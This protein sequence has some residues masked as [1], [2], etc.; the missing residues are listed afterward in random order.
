MKLSDLRKSMKKSAAR[1]TADEKKL[2]DFLQTE[3]TLPKH[4]SQKCSSKSTEVT[5][6][7]LA[8]TRDD[9]D[10]EIQSAVSKQLA[11]EL[12]VKTL[13]YDD[14]R[15]KHCKLQERHEAST[16]RVRNRNKK[17]KTRDRALAEK[18]EMIQEKTRKIKET[19]LALEGSDRK[20]EQ[21]TDKVKRLTADKKRLEQRLH[22]WQQKAELLSR[23]DFEEL[24]EYHEEIEK[25]KANVA[26]LE[27]DNLDLREQVEVFLKS[28]E[29]VSF[30]GG[31]Y[32]DDIRACYYELLSL[33]VG[34]RNVE[35]IIRSVLHNI[36]HKTVGRLP[37]Y[38]LASKMLAE[39]LVISHAQ[40][41]E[42][43][44]ET[45]F[46]TLH[47]DGTT[48]YGEHYGAVEI[49]TKESTYSIGMR[50][51]FSGSA[52]NTLDILQE[53]LTDIDDVGT[54][55]G[56][57]PALGKVLANVKNTM[58]DRHVVQKSF[59]ELLEN[60]RADIL[61]AVVENWDA[62]SKI[63]Q[64]QTTRLNNFF[65]G[66][67]FIT[68]L[69]DTAEAVLKEWE[70]TVTTSTL[71]KSLQN[72]GFF[73]SESGTQRL[74]RTACKAL[75]KRG[76]EQAG[77]PVQFSTFLRGKG[78]TKVP[79]ASF[80]GNRFNIIFYDA[81]GIYYLHSEILEFLE[82]HGTSNRL[83]CSVQAHL[84]VP[85]FVAGCK[86]L[87]LIDKLVTGPLWRTLEES[88][89]SI[90]DMSAHYSEMLEM[91]ERWS[92]DA[93][94]L[95]AGNESLPDGKEIADDPVRHKLLEPS[96]KYD[97]LAQEL[98]EVMF[99][100]FCTT[101]RRMLTDHLPGG[102]F[103]GKEDDSELVSE[104]ASVPKTNVISERDFAMLD[105]MI[106]DKPN[107]TTVALEAMILYANNQ[108]QM[109][110]DQHTLGDR[111]K[112]FAVA[113]KM[114]T[115]VKQKFHLR[116]TKIREQ[117]HERQQ[118]ELQTAERKRLKMLKDKEKWVDA[119]QKYGLWKSEQQIRQEMQ[120]LTAS[121]CKN[122]VITQIRFRQKVLCQ[123][124][125]D[126][127]VFVVTRNRKV[128]PQET[129]IENLKKLLPESSP[130]YPSLDTGSTVTDPIDIQTITENPHKLEGKR[131]EHLFYDPETDITM[132][133]KGT[134]LTLV[135]GTQSEFKVV[136]DDELD[137]Q[138][139]FPLLED[140]K[141]GDLRIL[142]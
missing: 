84:H 34:L 63:E 94:S 21:V 77:C 40:L 96:E 100:A 113:R 8:Y 50:S 19:K 95:L 52:Q 22:Y 126:S 128:L 35:P 6:G 4:R 38:A 70:A 107:A 97:I 76:S 51:M 15:K 114:A 132:W 2:H 62:M 142:K 27:E 98:L 3:F 108:T 5:S 115:T 64:E 49:S 110:L 135:P 129:L 36:A 124:Y 91:F 133:W 53:I 106:R 92:V 23:A 69:A 61:P 138:H 54:S 103:H 73:S 39:S 79:L 59:N 75:H 93:S 25:L 24:V 102:K 131:I 37:S 101:T 89:I 16:C 11:E 67:H 1:S 56:R 134:V 12:A 26:E 78:I 119:I 83:L 55:L 71:T 42:K 30:E 47:T 139:Q 14:L 29:I 87:G 66:L 32:V 72:R 86:A 123:T 7:K 112:I 33:N 31:M 122:A 88:S 111:E 45:G 43:L 81:A 141:N 17:I 117:R 105:R 85:E 48:K 136:Y 28:D 104:V 46:N 80:V 44:A 10:K 20:L 99:K 65:C 118:Q 82:V 41:G 130:L 109:W 90:L 127:S 116:R 120:K 121:E 140:L 9:Y 58:S 125:T 74:V 57:S 60:Y 18:E 68:G 137:Q 13:E